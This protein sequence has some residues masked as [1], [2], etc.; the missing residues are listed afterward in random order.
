M[1]NSTVGRSE[2]L[3]RAEPGSLLIQ[4]ILN[5][6]HKLNP[7]STEVDLSFMNEQSRL[8]ADQKNADINSDKTTHY[9]NPD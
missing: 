5:K 9:L 1:D 3:H 8:L 6:I 4:K 2:I 7:I